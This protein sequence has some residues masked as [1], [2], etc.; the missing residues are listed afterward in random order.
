MSVNRIANW[1]EE[2]KFVTLSLVMLIIWSVTITFIYLKADEI[3]KDPCSICAQKMGDKIYCQT[4]GLI[5]IKRTYFENG[6]I[7]DDKEEIAKMIRQE[8]DKKTP[9]VNFPNFS[10]VNN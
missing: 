4:Q 7:I 10:F 5:P 6:T 1:F 9:E 8:V 2:H 3:T